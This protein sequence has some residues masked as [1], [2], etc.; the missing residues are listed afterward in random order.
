MG[1]IGGRHRKELSLDIRW[2]LIGRPVEDRVGQGGGAFGVVLIGGRPV[3]PDPRA[4]LRTSRR[5]GVACVSSS[6]SPS[7]VS[8]AYSAWRSATVICAAK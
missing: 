8:R 6:I 4:A 1:D 5:F 7:R 2:W 3:G